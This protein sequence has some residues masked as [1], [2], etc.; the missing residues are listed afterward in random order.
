MRHRE[1]AFASILIGPCLLQQ[2]SKCD[3]LMLL[4]MVV[5]VVEIKANS[6]S[7]RYPHA[8]IDQLDKIDRSE[9]N[10]R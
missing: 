1:N 9:A 10:K 5:V 6:D 8:I 4:V 7:T 2:T 3:L